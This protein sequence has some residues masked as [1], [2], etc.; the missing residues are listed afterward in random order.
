MLTERKDHHDGGPSRRLLGA[1]A[2][3]SKPRARAWRCAELPLVSFVH[4][5]MNVDDAEVI[6]EAPE[7]P[8]RRKGHRKRDSTESPTS[9]EGCGGL[10]HTA[11]ETS[12]GYLANIFNGAVGGGAQCHAQPKLHCRLRLGRSDG[13]TTGEAAYAF[14]KTVD[15]TEML[16]TCNLWALHPTRLSDGKSGSHSPSQTDTAPGINL[17]CI[18]MH[19]LPDWLL[20]GLSLVSPGRTMGFCGAVTEPSQSPHLLAGVGSWLVVSHVVFRWSL[21]CGE[22]NAVEQRS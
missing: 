19:S 7:T 18:I 6:G 15:F 13:Y 22:T 1:A 4:T 8:S 17:L 5:A 14:G 2:T 21:H 12:P 16:I 3:S 9:G 20:P 11:N 10:S